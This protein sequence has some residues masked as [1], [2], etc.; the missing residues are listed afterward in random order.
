MASEDERRKEREWRT[1]KAFFGYFERQEALA[2]KEAERATRRSERAQVEREY[3][4][5]GQEQAQLAKWLK[6]HS[7]AYAANLEGMYHGDP[8]RGAVAKSRGAKKGRPD[9]EIFTPCPK[10]PTARGVA[11]ELKSTRPGA[12]ASPE[13][14]AWLEKLT[15][16]G[17][18]T[19]VAHGCA[20]AVE[21]LESLGYG[22]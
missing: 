10:H 15:H 20:D 13:Q 9:I 5:E 4:T 2:R 17:W 14:L 3:P 8:V 12:K 16:C 1:R 22:Q 11:I 19:Y 21:W 6:S 7:I 18:V